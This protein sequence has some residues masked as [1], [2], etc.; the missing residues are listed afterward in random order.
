MISVEKIGYPKDVWV[1]CPGCDQLY[2]VDRLFY[3]PPYD[4]LK[5][6]CP[7]CHLEFDKADSP[8]TWGE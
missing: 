2:Y 3:E 4:K 7:F 5:L 1:T 8:R 6:H